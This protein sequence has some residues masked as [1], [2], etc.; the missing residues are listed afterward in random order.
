MA[1][2]DSGGYANQSYVTLASGTYNDLDRAK[3]PQYTVNGITYPAFSSGSTKVLYILPTGGT[4]TIT[5]FSAVQASSG[6][7]FIIVNQDATGNN[8]LSFSH[9]TGSAVGNQFS[10]MSLN[11]VFI[12]SG[13]AARCTYLFPPGAQNGFWQFA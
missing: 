1:Y 11:S 3:I 10:N 13:G 6:H 7:T 5:G 4:V 8:N 9:L 12:Y 2:D